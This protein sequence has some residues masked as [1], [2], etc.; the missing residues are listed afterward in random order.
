MGELHRT[1]ICTASFLVTVQCFY[2]DPRDISRYTAKIFHLWILIQKHDTP[3]HCYHSSS[4]RCSVITTEQQFAS[5]SLCNKGYH[6]F[7]TLT[8]QR[9]RLCSNS[10][11]GVVVAIM[12][13][14][15]IINAFQHF[16][17]PLDQ[18]KIYLYVFPLLNKCSKRITPANFP[19]LTL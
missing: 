2:Y 19:I 14:S 8:S 17:A 16:C 18:V 3:K 6:T 13:R 10:N 5:V 15:G 4:F 11:H 9:L 1:G 7:V 12:V